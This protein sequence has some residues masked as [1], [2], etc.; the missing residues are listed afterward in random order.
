MILYRVKIKEAEKSEM[1]C[2]PLVKNFVP[3]GKY[4]LYL[5]V[6]SGHSFRDII[7]MSL[8]SY[9]EM[10]MSWHF[11]TSVFNPVR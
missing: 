3:I 9:S 1:K 4:I 8:Q 5:C 2:D 10:K 11:E 7:P 6:W